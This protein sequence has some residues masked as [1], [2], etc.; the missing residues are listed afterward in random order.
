VNPPVAIAKN[1]AHTSATKSPLSFTLL[2]RAS[3][4]SW[5]SIVADGKVVAEETLIAPAGTS[6][7]ATHQIVVRTGN[8]AGIGFLLNG[9]EIPKQGNE[10]EV[11]IYTFDATGLRETSPAQ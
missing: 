3:E 11:K 1:T 10:G 9:K 6:V 4:T 8:A 5:V 2:I 7:R